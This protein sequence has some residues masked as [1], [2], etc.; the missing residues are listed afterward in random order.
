[1][2]RKLT[3]KKEDLNE[4]TLAELGAVAGAAS[5][6]GVCQAASVVVEECD[7]YTTPLAYCLTL[8]GSRCIY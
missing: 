2:T 4:L 5:A 1:M 3:L 8:A 6:L 7:G